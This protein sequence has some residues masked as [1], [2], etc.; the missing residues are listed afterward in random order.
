MKRR[1]SG[2]IVFFLLIGAPSVF[3]HSVVI[4]AGRIVWNEAE[5]RIEFD[6]DA[7]LIEHERRALGRAIGA[8][9]LARLLDASFSIADEFGA[10][11]DGAAIETVSDGNGVTLS[12]TAPPRCAAVAIR[13]RPAGRFAA[14][15]R[16][17][18]LRHVRS[19]DDPVLIRLTPQFSHGV[20]IRKHGRASGALAEWRDAPSVRVGRHS[21]EGPL[22]Q[23]E[24]PVYLMADLVGLTMNDATVRADWSARNREPITRWLGESLFC[25]DGDGNDLKCALASVVLL[26]PDG[27]IAKEAGVGLN[28]LTTR[29]RVTVTATTWPADGVGYLAWRGFTQG[30]LRMAVIAGDD[31]GRVLP[32]LSPVQHVLRIDVSEANQLKLSVLAAADQPSSLGAMH[33]R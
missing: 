30:V 16:Q 22:L 24:S 26:L 9:E 6:I 18:Q 3:A 23:F 7:H 4:Y 33:A 14:L 27:R 29:L 13:Y 12:Y 32:D 28:V 21:S 1:P 25:T 19:G 2:F 5:L 20:V 15:Q 31:P 10:P 11:V 8:Q 17:F